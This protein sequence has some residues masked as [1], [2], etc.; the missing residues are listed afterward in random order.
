MTKLV[1]LVLG[2][3]LV[4]PATAEIALSPRDAIVTT[5]LQ[6]YAREATLSTERVC[7]MPTLRPT[8]ET[9]RTSR[10]AYW[11]DWSTLDEKRFRLRIVRSLDR[12]LE[13]AVRTKFSRAKHARIV[14]APTPLILSSKDA[15][16]SGSCSID[17][18]VGIVEQIALSRPMVSGNYAF[19]EV[20]SMVHGTNPPP[21]LVALTMKNG[22]WKMA[23]MARRDLW[24]D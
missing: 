24:Y 5:V 18:N 10:R 23:S 21:Q 20:F 2:L 15:P 6:H 3:A 13:K 8:L 11:T 14:V 7:V 22:Q 16:K 9:A 17:D 12:A 19:V 4:T 1:A